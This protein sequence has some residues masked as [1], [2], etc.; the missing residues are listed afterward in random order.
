MEAG[1]PAS[2]EALRPGRPGRVVVVI[3][4]GLVAATALLAI[5]SV[6]RALRPVES[7]AAAYV[8]PMHR[9][10]TSDRP[11]S[12]PVCGMRLEH[13]A[14]TSSAASA[15]A[16]AAPARTVPV[17]RK[18]LEQQPCAREREQQRRERPPAAS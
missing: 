1:V 9:E 5:F 8:C 3:R 11:G 14:A 10:V 4:W 15:A 13:L 7:A 18:R 16:S 2:H 12:C 6:A 17:G